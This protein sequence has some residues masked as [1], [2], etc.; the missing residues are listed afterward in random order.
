MPPRF[1]KDTLKFLRALKRNN[2]REWFRSRKDEYERHVRAPMIAV[3]EQLA[4]DFPRVAPELVASPK[5]SL[6]RI[7]RDTRFSADKSPLKTNAAAVFNWKGMARHQ[8]AG[9][10]FEVAP[11][12]VWIGG[13]MYMPEAQQLVKVRQHIAETWPEIKKIATSKALVNRVSALHGDCL[14][15]VPRGFP[16]D[17]PAVE[18]LKYKQFLAS[19]EFPAEFAAADDFYP[20][21]LA[22]FTAMVPLVRF[23]NAPLT[24]NRG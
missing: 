16:A 5:A 6:F 1:T 2:D 11:Q 3:I 18:F 20:T 10:Y 17:H 13:G 12:W 15:R 9:L 19:R 7:Y 8:G 14:T 24:G 4:K 21:L 23:L 22:T